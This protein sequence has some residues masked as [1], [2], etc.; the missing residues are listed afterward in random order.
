MLDKKQFEGQWGANDAKGAERFWWQRA[1]WIGDD[2]EMLQDT[3]KEEEELFARER[4]ANTITFSE[5]K[6]NEMLQWTMQN[7]RVVEWEVHLWVEV[8]GVRVNVRVM[9][10]CVQVDHYFCPLR[11]PPAP[12]LDRFCQARRSERKSS[13]EPLHLIDYTVQIG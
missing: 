4:L 13:R 9:Q 5:P 7:F 2:L 1:F 3:G 6:W 10:H 8:R 11:Q 12:P